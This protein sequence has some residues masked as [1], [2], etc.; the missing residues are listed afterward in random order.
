MQ[1]KNT[2]TKIIKRILALCGAAALVLAFALYFARDRLLLAEEMPQEETRSIEVGDVITEE[3]VM[4][5]A[6]VLAQQEVTEPEGA[7]LLENPD[8]L[9]TGEEVPAELSEGGE[10]AEE[11]LAEGIPADGEEVVEIL[12]DHSGAAAEEGADAALSEGET[13]AAGESAPAGEEGAI[14]EE[15]AEA[16]D[17][18]TTAADGRTAEAAQG[19]EADT[20]AQTSEGTAQHAGTESVPAPQE[21]YMP[22]GELTAEAPDGAIVTVIA[23]EGAVP[24]GSYV[25]ADIVTEDAAITEAIG[26]AEQGKEIVSIVA[27]DIRI[28]NPSGE[29]I[30]PLRPVQVQIQSPAVKADED[31]SVFHIDDAGTAEK[32]TD[33]QGDDNAVF[34]VP[35]EHFSG[36]APA[37]IAAETAGI[38]EMIPETEGTA[39]E[40]AGEGD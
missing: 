31:T 34:D 21:I 2:K 8:L 3:G 14:T 37:D 24:E 27:Y 10:P 30:Q 36:A 9:L 20:K 39:V 11:G 29:E 7:E 13:T 40:A 17:G 19:T 32:I 12:L 26:A 28:F 35:L 16:A 6:D 1:G 18:E 23:P 15:G 33:V 22:A 25:T 38:P 5:A 4:S